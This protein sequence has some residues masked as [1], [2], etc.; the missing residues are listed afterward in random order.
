MFDFSDHIKRNT[1]WHKIK[2]TQLANF[3]NGYADTDGQIKNYDNM[4]DHIRAYYFRFS[5]CSSCP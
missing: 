2:S 4:L 3:Y 5:F 1:K